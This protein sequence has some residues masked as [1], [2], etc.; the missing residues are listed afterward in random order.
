[1]KIKNVIM[2]VIVACGL[3]TSAFAVDTNKVVAPKDVDTS[4]FNANEFSINVG[5]FIGLNG[6]YDA[7]FFGGLSYSITRNFVIETSVPFYNSKELNVTSASAG[8]AFRYPVARVLAPTIRV[9]ALY[10]W[11]QRDFNYYVGGALE[12]KLSKKWSL[13]PGINYQLNDFNNFTKGTW[14]PQVA[15]RLT[16]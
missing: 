9:G 6:D 12:I 7:N 4:L 11:N 1:M 13:L 10:D 3:A 16:F 15:V 14:L 5:T 8:L 2:S